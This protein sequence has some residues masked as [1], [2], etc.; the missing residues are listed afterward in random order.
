[1][2]RNDSST[3]LI[4]A[5]VL[6]VVAAFYLF[7]FR[8]PW[9]P[10]TEIGADNLLT[11]IR[12]LPPFVLLI[13]FWA[14][15][16]SVQVVIKKILPEADD[17]IIPLCVLLSGFSLVFLAGISLRVHARPFFILQFLYIL[18][19][20]ILIPVTAVLFSRKTGWLYLFVKHH[21]HILAFIGFGLLYLT[22]KYGQEINHRRLWL[23]VLG[24]SIQT[25]EFVK[26]ILIVFTGSLMASLGEDMK[27]YQSPAV[28]FISWLKKFFQWSYIWPIIIVLL[29]FMQDLGPAMLLGIFYLSFVLLTGKRF[30]FLCAGVIIF[31]AIAYIAYIYQVPASIWIRIRG[32][33]DYAG[34][35]ADIWRSLLV[36]SSGGFF[37]KGLG[38]ADTAYK[39]ANVQSDFIFS[40]MAEELGVIG[41]LFILICYGCLIFRVLF[42]AYRTMAVYE[43]T[44]ALGVA[45]ILALPLFVSALGNLGMIAQTGI[46][47]PLLSFGGSSLISSAIALGMLLGVSSGGNDEKIL[48]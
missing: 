20:M 42:I 8:Q 43:K 34:V 32:C 33:M 35:N 9:Q 30:E 22:F 38:G 1:M 47:I 5:S 16:I 7:Y 25:V 18:I 45:L 36:I 15:A 37:G 27:D 41:T 11:L 31:L 46:N 13:A 21:P 24:V 6:L 29:I 40:F 28:S 23:N 17:F 3:Y 10:P 14:A 26:V 2:T 4:N 44:I 39:I 19:A 48:S 12:K